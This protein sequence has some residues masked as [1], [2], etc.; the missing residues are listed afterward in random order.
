MD[1]VTF[2]RGFAI[3]TSLCLASSALAQSKYVPQVAPKCTVHPEIGCVYTLEQVKTLYKLDSEIVKLRRIN[4]LQAQKLNI[5][6][7]II[8]AGKK[9]LDLSLKNTALFHSRM[10]ELTQKLIETDKL[11]QESRAK[12]MWGNYIAWGVAIAVSA[13]LTGYVIADQVGK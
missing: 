1:T 11:Y 13:A 9:Q 7:Q 2:L 10:N 12:P 3:F 5:Q 8:T 6:E 4:L